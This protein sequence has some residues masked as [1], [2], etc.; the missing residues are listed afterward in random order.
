V[1]RRSLVYFFCEVRIEDRG[2]PVSSSGA[3]RAA[4]SLAA[5]AFE[6]RITFLGMTRLYTCRPERPPLRRLEH[7]WDF[8]ESRFFPLA[9]S[10]TA[11][12]LIRA[13]AVVAWWELCANAAHYRQAGAEKHAGGGECL[14]P[15]WAGGRHLLG[16]WRI[17]QF[18][19]H[20]SPI[21][22]HKSRIF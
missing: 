4:K 5:S 22:S 2:L 16:D 7:R 17:A 14:F 20:E 10:C 9:F 8:T 13:R 19:H 12:Q 1:G 11:G 15:A 21:A 3:I 6:M 18:A